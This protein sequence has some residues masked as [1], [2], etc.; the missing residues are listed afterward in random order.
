MGITLELPGMTPEETTPAVMTEAALR[1]T[2]ETEMSETLKQIEQLSVEEQKQIED[3]AAKIDLHDS[4]II[5]RYGESTQRKM[6]SLTDN[7]LQGV[8]GRDVGEVGNLV[9]EMTVSLKS[10]NSNVDAFEKSLENKILGILRS[11]KKRAEELQVKYTSVLGTLERVK[12]DLMRQHTTLMVD[13]KMLDDLYSENLEYYKELTMYILAGNR[14]L[15]YVRNGELE[16]LR[17]KAEN[18]GL[19]NDV[20]S[21][22]DLK[23]RC[24]NFELQLHDLELTLAVCLQ[25][26]PQIRMIQKTD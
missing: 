13:I 2:V 12:K 5:T 15:E 9:A 17:L 26:A 20:F 18:S 25:T 21:Y 16:E 22:S 19:Q 24:E 7:A 3:F 23:D 14:Q 11:V 4:T 10:F 6:A 1:T 8:V